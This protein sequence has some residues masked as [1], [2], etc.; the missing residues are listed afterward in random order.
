[1]RFFEFADTD[2]GLD[3]FVMTLRNF[4]G[5]AASKKAPA[6]L[7]WASLQKI[8]NDNGFEFAAD[9]ETFKSIYDSSPIIQSLVKNFNADGIELK[10]PGAEEPGDEGEPTPNGGDDSEE[11][12]AKIAA[13]AAPQQLA[14]QQAGVQA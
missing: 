11:A 8:T 14:Q 2:S 9:Y 13:S 10:V 6:Q 5:R 3:K 7:N 4:I 12:V 1:M